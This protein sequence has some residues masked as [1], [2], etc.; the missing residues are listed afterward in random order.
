LLFARPAPQNMKIIR[1]G[2]AH[3]WAVNDAKKQEL[4]KE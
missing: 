1:I 3:Q 2:D 4:P